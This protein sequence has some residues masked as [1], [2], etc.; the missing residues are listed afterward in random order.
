MYESAARLE[1]TLSQMQRNLLRIVQNFN[2]VQEESNRSI[3]NSSGNSDFN[4]LHKVRYLNLF[5][6]FNFFRLDCRRS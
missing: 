6:I 2:S 5:M 4:Q 3:A 1:H